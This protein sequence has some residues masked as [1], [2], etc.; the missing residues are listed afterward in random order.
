MERWKWSHFYL[1]REQR[2]E[3]KEAFKDSDE[4]SFDKGKMLP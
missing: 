1:G 4:P 2:R 3:Q